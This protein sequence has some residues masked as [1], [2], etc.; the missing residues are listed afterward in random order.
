MKSSLCTFPIIINSWPRSGTINVSL[1]D[2]LTLTLACLSAQEELRVKK[3][4]P[5]SRAAGQSV[6]SGEGESGFQWVETIGSHCSCSCGPF[7]PP[8]ALYPHFCL[9][10][11]F[12]INAYMIL[13]HLLK[14]D[15]RAFHKPSTLVTFLIVARFIDVFMRCL[16]LGL[17]GSAPINAKIVHF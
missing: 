1:S 14:A 11:L 6:Q 10:Y 15:D 9:C 17:R 7:N 12:I 13:F 5:V 4:W 2:I 8:L 3:Q 16:L